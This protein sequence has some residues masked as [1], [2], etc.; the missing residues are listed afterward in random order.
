MRDL[1]P[2]VSDAV[3]HFWRTRNKQSKSGMRTG[4]RGSRGA[5]TGGQQLNGFT[6]LV[7]QLLIESGVAESCIHHSRLLE[8]P[9]WFRAE[10]KWDLVVVHDRQLL[11]AV[12]FKSQIGPSFGNNFNNRTE[13]ALGSATDLWA[14]YRE[15]AFAPSPKPWLGY[16]MLLEDC[17]GSAS[18]VKCKAP[19]FNPFPEF[20]AASYRKRYEILIEKL[21]RDRLYDGACLL[22]S[23][24]AGGLKGEYREPSMELSFS[25]MIAPLVGHVLALCKS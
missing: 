18:P 13:E 6:E 9:G 4:D 7:A 19:H 16:F 25:R 12:E 20:D 14:A 17:E 8:L 5:V 1:Q 10:K 22:V 2:R 11:A 21:I 15:G 24:S 23:S 3:R